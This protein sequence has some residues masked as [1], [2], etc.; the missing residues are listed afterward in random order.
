MILLALGARRDSSIRLAHACKSGAS[1]TCLIVCC[2][3]CMHSVT[4]LLLSLCLSVASVRLLYSANEVAS[5]G[6]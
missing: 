2:W 1:V 4:C 5:Q 3:P 6:P